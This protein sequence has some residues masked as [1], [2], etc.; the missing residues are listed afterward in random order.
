MTIHALHKRQNSD[1]LP[2]LCELFNLSLTMRLFANGTAL[3]QIA[4]VHPF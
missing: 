2:M 4:L 3:T 1:E